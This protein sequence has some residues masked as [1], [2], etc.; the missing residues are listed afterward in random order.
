MQRAARGAVLE[1]VS[2]VASLSVRFG[3]NL[4]LTRLLAPDIFGL[5]AMVQMVLFALHMLADVG[6]SQAVVAHP[7]G[8]DDDFLNVTWSIQVV[9]GLGLT[10]VTLAATWPAAA[11][12]KE[13]RMLWI[14]PLSS[15]TTF[16]HS[17]ASS[18]MFTCARH[19]RVAPVVTMELAAQFVAVVINIVGAFL[20][21]GVLALLMGQFVAA[22]VE[23]VWSH[24][25]PGTS[26]RDR[27]NMDP[28][29]RRE[30]LRFG[31]WIFLSSALTVVAMR[32]DS[33]LLGRLLGTGSLGLYNLAATIADLPE[34]LGLRIVNS[35]VYPTLSTTYNTAPENFVKVF[36][37][38]RLYFDALAHTA[39]GGLAAL[40]VHIID[41]LYD[42]RYQ[43]AGVMLGVFAV[44]TSM[45][46]ITAPWEIAFFARGHTHF[47][48]RRSLIT[49]AA[50]MI[51]MPVGYHYFGAAGVIWGTV[52]A[53]ATALL[54]LWPPAY[55][56]GLL[57]LHR[58]L[59]VPLFLALGYGL[60]RC[61][62]WGLSVLLG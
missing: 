29:T 32:G 17:F 45:G 14:L 6:L 36:Y 26:H 8:D 59:L 50:V 28:E 12:F 24:F 39:L 43:G 11:W 13:P 61:V 34:S 33:A 57:R 40:S 31:R 3:S 38:V 15:A 9:R 4:I 42:D 48:F 51:A 37:R 49:S 47:G 62:A 58:E 18:R 16:V 44:R 55:A 2:Y 5:L 7:R 23:V 27:W 1:T 52:A 25:L 54:V 30:I 20:G 22:C 60:G 21:Y 46:L 53:R 35:V 41:L 19:V 10:L 56:E